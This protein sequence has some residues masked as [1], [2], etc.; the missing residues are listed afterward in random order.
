MRRWHH[1]MHDY[2]AYK[3]AKMNKGKTVKHFFPPKS[4]N[5]LIITQIITLKII[6]NFDFPFK[7]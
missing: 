7:I 4:L 2:I 6:F 1:I 3:N 5:N